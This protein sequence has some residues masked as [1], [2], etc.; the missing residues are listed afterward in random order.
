M[1][2]VSDIICQ[3][4]KDQSFLDGEKTLHHQRSVL[5]A[6]LFNMFPQIST[7]LERLLASEKSK[8]KEI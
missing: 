4:I 3:N 7:Q 8:L 1:K 2:S 6:L 5:Q